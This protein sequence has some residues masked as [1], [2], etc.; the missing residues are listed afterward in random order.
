MFN[1]NQNAQPTSTVLMNRP[2]TGDK[3]VKDSMAVIQ[4]ATAVVTVVALGCALYNSFKQPDPQRN[5][6]DGYQG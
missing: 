4:I 5:R 6:F 1:D 3:F 2:T